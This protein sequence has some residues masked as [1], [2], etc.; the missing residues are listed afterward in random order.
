[1]AAETIVKDKDA[2]AKEAVAWHLEVDPQITEIYRFISAN[3]DAPDEPLKLLDVTNATAETGQVDFFG[4]S[5]GPGIPFLSVMGSIT[6]NEFQKVIEGKM[7]L[8]GT[9]DLQ[10]AKRID[11]IGNK[12]SHLKRLR[13]PEHF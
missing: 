5:S 6:P 12:F 4:F 8:P 11:S 7:T 9:W 13:R 1:M 10:N 2:V 3:E